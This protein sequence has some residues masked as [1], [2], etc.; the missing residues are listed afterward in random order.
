MKYRIIVKIGR[1]NNKIYYPQYKYRFWPFYF[2]FMDMFDGPKYHST[3]ENA[4]KTIL[5]DIERSYKK[6][7]VRNEVYYY[8]YRYKEKAYLYE[9]G[10]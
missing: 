8:R 7:L 4:E 6:K 9:I 5:F 2:S 1:D 10:I 3:K